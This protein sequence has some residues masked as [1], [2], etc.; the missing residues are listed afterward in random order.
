MKKVFFVCL[1]GRVPFAL[2]RLIQLIRW[3]MTDS[4]FF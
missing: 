2:L 4:Q 3:Q 1:F